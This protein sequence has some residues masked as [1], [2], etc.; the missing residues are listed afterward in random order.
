MEAYVHRP[1]AVLTGLP[2]VADPQAVRELLAEH[3]TDGVEIERVTL[4]D[5][6]YR[7]ERAARFVYELELRDTTGARHTHFMHGWLG[8][9]AQ[10]GRRY[11]RFAQH[12]WHTPR[13]GPAFLH[14]PEL[15]FL[16]WG[17]PNDSKLRLESLADA[18]R[19]LVTLRGVSG[20]SH[21]T[22]QRC[23]SRIVH[24]VPR[25]RIVMHHV[26][27]PGEHH[28]YTKSYGNARGAQVFSMTQ[29]LWERS[30]TDAE[31][32]RIARPL[33]YLAESR[34]LVQEALVGWHAIDENAWP[35]E[36]P[37]MD[38]LGRCLA[39]LHT[40]DVSVH[41]EWSHDRELALFE[42]VADAV[43]RFDAALCVELDEVCRLA[44][45]TAPHGDAG[46]HVPVHGAFR[47]KQML[48]AGDQVALVDLD[49][50]RRGDPV[51][52][53][54]S[55]VAQLQAR[56]ASGRLAADAADAAVAALL[57]TYRR[58]VPWSVSEPTL[59]WYVALRLVSKH[60]IGPVNHLK[61]DAGAR[62]RALL[63][64]SGRILN[65]R[66]AVVS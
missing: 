25:K 41:S 13:F 52:D 54:G 32:F 33:A 7:P 34:T 48:A 38:R 6:A 3:F 8:S 23:T 37:R 42:K 12:R 18:A 36:T 29:E 59:A 58:E 27:D 63:E 39:R 4:H 60:A 46:R 51:A 49:G 55:L 53:L 61:R 14:F 11:A 22:A 9:T 2:R 56:V 66:R 64:A 17:F 19:A 43:R 1:D 16:V 35:L 62:I 20:T 44:R 31:A 28:V 21:A 10:I 24:Y 45:R 65:A 50:L 30:R 15:G 5:F 57:A 47:F 40:S 26:L